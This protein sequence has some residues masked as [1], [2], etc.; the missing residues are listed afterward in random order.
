MKSEVKVQ[1][2]VTRSVRYA[3]FSHTRARVNNLRYLIRPLVAKRVR[4]CI[5]LSLF[6]ARYGYATSS[7]FIAFN[8]PSPGNA[9]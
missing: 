3:C 4:E 8:M 1:S 7:Q 9:P 2:K 5:A 6:E